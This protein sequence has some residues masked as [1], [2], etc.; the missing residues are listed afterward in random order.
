MNW[1]TEK[2]KISEL[3]NWE[4]NP[5]TITE[6][7]YEELK[8]NVGDLGNFEPLVI[9][10]NSVVIASGYWQMMKSEV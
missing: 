6:K 2:R 7:A 10:A 9:N 5:R 1:H 3:R 4:S 8:K